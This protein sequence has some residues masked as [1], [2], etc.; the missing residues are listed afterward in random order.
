[1]IPYLIQRGKEVMPYLLDSMACRIQTNESSRKEVSTMPLPGGGDGLRME[2]HYGNNRN[3]RTDHGKD[4]ISPAVADRCPAAA[5]GGLHQRNKKKGVTC[6]SLLY[7]FYTAIA[8]RLFCWLPSSTDGTFVIYDGVH[9]SL[10][11]KSSG[12]KYRN[13]YTGRRP[14]L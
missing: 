6:G 9:I 2:G 14:R 13:P 12:I 8:I 5:G 1:M 3:Q 11:P 4:R 10:T 7:H